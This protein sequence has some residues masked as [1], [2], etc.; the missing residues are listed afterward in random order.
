MDPSEHDRHLARMVFTLQIIVGAM[1][2]GAAVFLGIGFLTPADFGGRSGVAVAVPFLTYFSAGVAVV[3]LAARMVVSAVM[4]NLARQRIADGVVRGQACHAADEA[5]AAFQSSRTGQLWQAYMTIAIIRA[6]LV[7]G[8][9]LLA[10]MAYFI[11]RQPAAAA[12]AGFLILVLLLQ[13][14]T[15]NGVANWIED[16]DRLIEQS[17]AP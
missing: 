1:A 6:A 13:F 2:L 4:T 14:P 5:T 8:A 3:S 15:R 9:A 16:Q 12:I 10:A 17:A 7:E 11:D